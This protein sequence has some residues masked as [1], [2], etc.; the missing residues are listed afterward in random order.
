M[1]RLECSH[2]NDPK[3]GAFESLGYANLSRHRIPPDATLCLELLIDPWKKTA[4][5]TLFQ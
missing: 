1:A 5:E 4:G 3:L 2:L